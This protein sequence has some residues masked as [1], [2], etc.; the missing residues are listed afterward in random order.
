M[1]K[2]LG[3]KKFG[4]NVLSNKLNQKYFKQRGNYTENH[5]HI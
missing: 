5:L 3:R 4:R 2:L 1:S